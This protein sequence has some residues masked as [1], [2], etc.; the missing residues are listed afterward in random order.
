MNVEDG[1]K[2]NLVGPGEKMAVEWGNVLF[3]PRGFPT[4]Q[5]EDRLALEETRLMP[6][7]QNVLSTGQIEQPERAGLSRFLAIQTLRY[8]EAFKGRLGRGQLLALDLLDIKKF[9]DVAAFNTHLSRQEIFSA[10]GTAITQE[11]F[12]YFS[13]LGDDEL[14][15]KIQYF[16]DDH[17]QS[18]QGLNPNSLIDAAGQIATFLASLEWELLKSPSPAFILSDRPVPLRIERPFALGLGARYALRVNTSAA[19]T[20]GPLTARIASPSEIDAVNQEVTSRAVEW[21][22]GPN[23]F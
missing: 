10:T 5:Y 12:D 7:L 17:F 20:P 23:P 6:A 14:E 4:D 21:L 13:A 1:R 19:A 15:E 2:L 8:P 22:C 3:D 16:F 9:S 18:E 11:E